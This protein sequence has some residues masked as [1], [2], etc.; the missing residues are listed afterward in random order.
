MGVRGCCKEQNRGRVLVS[1]LLLNAG[2]QIK[3]S[4]MDCYLV[5]ANIPLIMSTPLPAWILGSI[6]TTIV[7]RI[8]LTMYL[9]PHK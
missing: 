3:T 4:P 9:M 7:A 2:V 5:F 6:V 1:N 8:F